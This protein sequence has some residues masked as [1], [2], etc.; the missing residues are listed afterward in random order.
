MSDQEL[1]RRTLSRALEM[2]GG[3]SAL[4]AKLSVTDTH[5]S[6]WLHGSQPIPE[7]VFL[8]LVDLVVNTGESVPVAPRPHGKPLKD[9]AA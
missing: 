7:H 6:S 4:C 8:Q 9:S 2:A 1:Y 3:R 5:L